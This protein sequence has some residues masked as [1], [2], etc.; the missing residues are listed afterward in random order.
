MQKH[1]IG[2][3]IDLIAA[4]RSGSRA[5]PLTNVPC[6]VPGMWYAKSRR[7]ILSMRAVLWNEG[8]ESRNCNHRR[9]G[10]NRHKRLK[11]FVPGVLNVFYV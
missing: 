5:V 7:R 4:Y 3:D 10:Y 6:D 11:I 9:L 2:S 8:A 1:S